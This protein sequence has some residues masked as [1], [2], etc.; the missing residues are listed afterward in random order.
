MLFHTWTFAVFFLVFYPVYLSVRRTSLG[1]P[2][3]LVSSYCFYGWWNPLYLLLILYST[4]IDYWVVGRMDRSPRRR[5]WLIVSL[6][7]NL[8]ILV[9]FKYAAFLTTNL[10]L[11]LKSVG[12]SWEI[13]EPDL[14]LPVGISFFTFQSMSYTIDYYRGQVSREASFIRFA[15][16][17]SLFPQLVAGPIERARHLLPQLSRVE[18]IP[19]SRIA[20]GASVFVTGLFKKVACAN[21][22]AL[23]VDSVYTLPENHTAPALILATVC[24]AWQIYFDF[25]GY[26]DMARGLARMMGF[27][28]SINFHHPYLATGLGD[29]WRRWHISLS[30][31]FRD[32]V[33]IPL[34]GS[35]GSAVQTYWNMA[36]TLIIS[37]IWHGAAWTFVAWG[38]FHALAR[39]LTR[40]ME[41]AA[42]YQNKVP[43]LVKRLWVFGMV[44]L[45]WIFFRAMSWEDAVT[46]YR[47]IFAPLSTWTMP[48]FPL[49]FGALIL[50]VWAHQWLE[51][52]RW[53]SWLERP[54][55]R[56]S[57]MVL[58]LTYL[59][60]FC[61]ADEQ[62]FIYFQF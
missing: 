6:V 33:Y 10:N 22:L 17:V 16:F 8:G 23:Y 59:W 5:F 50:L 31:W 2:W 41:S 24:F 42:W 14:M 53:K 36:L 51:E 44:C 13:P 32:Y 35:R 29:F 21:A 12:L 38:V 18:S 56:L 61:G 37:G 19:L 43:D 34:G 55:V 7:N 20:D 58:L 3:L 60:I 4:W 11:A 49:A 54:A 15:T 28:L 26:T 27:D 47:G 46:I 30:S 52:S 25:S 48:D 40:G 45:S 9:S 39:V 57:S 1:I 62:A